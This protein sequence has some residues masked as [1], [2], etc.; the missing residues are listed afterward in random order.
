MRRISG[1]R[2]VWSFV[3]NMATAVLGTA[4]DQW[5]PVDV[6]I[7]DLNSGTLVQT[8]STMGKD[9]AGRL[10]HRIREDLD[11]LEVDEFVSEWG[12]ALPPPRP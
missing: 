7:T 9:E 12:L 2:L 11:S 5:P 6:L 8:L 1:G 3:R 4:N 10:V